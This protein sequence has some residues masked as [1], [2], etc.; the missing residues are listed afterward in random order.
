MNRCLLLLSAAA[1]L[2]AACHPNAAL[3]RQA[4]EGD[5]L[6][7]YEYG[8]RL[9]TGQKVRHADPPRAVEWLRTA[10]A[11]GYAP[12]QSVLALCYERGLGTAPDAKEAKRLYTLAAE[13]GHAPACRALI[14]QEMRAGNTAGATG[15]LRSMAEGGNPAAQLLYGKSCLKG[16]FG[17][18]RVSEGVRFIRYA[19][20]Q[21]NEEAC[22]LMA[23]CYANGRGVPK[24]DAMAEGWKKNVPETL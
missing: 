17:A 3:I 16:E 24:D 2:L 13:Q 12:A 10:A 20:M 9:L 14:A 5:P 1:V 6:A 4:T 23:D 11:D 8:R 7:Q 18:A 15:W 22:L 19:A 21:G